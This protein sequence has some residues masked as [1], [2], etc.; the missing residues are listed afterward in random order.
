VTPEILNERIEKIDERV[1]DLET[2]RVLRADLAK[3]EDRMRVQETTSAK[4]MALL[5]FV[6]FVATMAAGFVGKMI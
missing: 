3:L 6:V 1:R 4:G 5:A 2:D